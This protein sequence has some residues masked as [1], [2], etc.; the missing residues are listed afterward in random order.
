MKITESEEIKARRNGYAQ[1]MTFVEVIAWV[2]VTLGAIVAIL[3]FHKMIPD[4]PGND[5]FSLSNLSAYG[6]YLQGATASLWTLA[7]FMFIFASFRAQRQQLIQQDEE[8]NA[9]KE[10]FEKQQI[11]QA[12]QL[13]A[14]KQQFKEQHESIKL[15]NFENA[16]FQLLNLQNQIVGAL[17]EGGIEGRDCFGKWHGIFI[18]QLMYYCN[19]KAYHEKGRIETGLMKNEEVIEQWN[20]FYRKYESDLAHYFRN[21]YHVFKFV[22]ISHVADKRRYTSLARA[23][24]SKYELFFIFLNCLTEPGQGFKPVVEEFGLLEHLDKS[25]RLVQRYLND[26]DES[27]YK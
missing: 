26:Y 11:Q 5:K 1:R 27:A 12:A 14:Q 7:G 22:K 19:T 25:S 2:L 18:D 10:Q 21:L 15:Q 6:S 23:Q 4:K 17:R 13:E 24:L 3:G 9:Q 16:F 8:L 20:K